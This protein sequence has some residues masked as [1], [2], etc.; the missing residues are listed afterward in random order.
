[1]TL[2]VPAQ[3]GVAAVD[4]AGDAGPDPAARRLWRRTWQRCVL[5]PL[6]VLAP[7]VAL[8]PTADHRFNLYWHGGLFR[9]DPFRIVPHT[10][11]SVGGY[12]TLGN[13]RPLGRMLEKSLDLLAY[14]LGDLLGVPVTI[15][16]RLV[17]FAAAAALTVTA[18]VL[19][20]S[21]VA[22]GPL[23]GR[24]PST[25]AA[26][27]PFAIGS[28][29][30]AAGSASPTVLFGGLYLLSAALVLLVAAAAC[31]AV[32][33]VGWW[34]GAA[35]VAAGAALAAFNE[36][37][38]L[39]PPFA[40]A[41]VAIRHRAV[42]GERWRTIASGPAARTLGLLWLGFVPVFATV[43]LVIRAH[44]AAGGC[45]RGSDLAVGPGVVAAV[46]A[47]MVAWLPPLAWR[48]A[49]EGA[50]RLWV[51]GAVTVLAL[52]VLGALAW[53]AVR[54]LPRLT[55]VG[56]REAY[57]LAGAA[58]VLLALAATLGSLN[59]DVQNLV[60]HHRW[61]QGWRDSAVTAVAGGIALTAVALGWSGPRR[62]AALVM[63]LALA[64]TVSTAANKSYRDQ[65]AVR[66]PALLANRVAGEMADFD[67]TAAGDARRCAL[68]AEFRTL[69]ADSAFSLQRFDQSL[70]VAARQQANVRFCELTR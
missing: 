22:C 56:R 27:V 23:F 59:A 30:V 36:I 6:T 45:Y 69:H 15:P 25:V 47:R 65:L 3:P 5:V 13:F 64:A 58:G 62:H 66:E 46:P 57:G 16:F 70:D 60:A 20:E 40:T 48:S 14:T 29:L 7:L 18:V 24:A 32:R 33:R 34:R 21:V 68:R 43:R 67:R 19:A 9:D 44:C 35:L 31:R 38:Y 26:T 55:P 52:L 1:M 12:L 54:D 39:A 50:H 8:A 10:L 17:S 51:P 41:A 61:G 4:E 11:H 2:L 63:V 37:A 28:G 53:R 49:T 42:L